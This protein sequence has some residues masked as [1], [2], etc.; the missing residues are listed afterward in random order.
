MAY[1]L[2]IPGL[3][4]LT[5]QHARSSGAVGDPAHR[6]PPLQADR[7]LSTPEAAGVSGANGQPHRSSRA[8]REL[9][10]VDGSPGSPFTP[11]QARFVYQ[12]ASP[13]ALKER[14]P[15]N[16]NSLGKLFKQFYP[17]LSQNPLIV[18]HRAED[19]CLQ[20]VYVCRCFRQ[21]FFDFVKSSSSPLFN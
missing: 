3:L 5:P 13:N 7:L 11:S 16:V 19:D 15:K 14:L 2:E 10:P 20:L 1:E 18:A 12:A 9:F 4:P 21:E 6:S 8:R 17:V